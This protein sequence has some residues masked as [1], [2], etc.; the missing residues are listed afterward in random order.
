MICRILVAITDL[1]KK[2][3]IPPF[4]PLAHV[5]EVNLRQ[6]TPE[7]SIRAFRKH[8][9]RLQELGVDVCW[10][11]PVHPIGMKNRKGSLGS[12]YCVRDYNDVNPEFGSLPDF[13]EMV[14]DMHA[15]GMKLVIDWVGNHAAWDNVWV[16]S[17]PEYFL[18]DTNGRFLS[19]Y[20]W[21][22]VIQFNHSHPGQQEAMLDAMAFWVREMGIDGFRADFAHLV[23][24]EFW[25]RARTKLEA[26]KPNLIWLAEAEG[27]DIYQVFDINYGWEWMHFTERF[28]MESMPVSAFRDFIIKEFVEADPS[29]YQLLFTCTHDEN[30]NRGTE[31]ERY[32]IFAQAL[33]VCMYALPLSIPMIYG[34]QEIPNHKR[35]PFFDKDFMV[36]PEQPALTDFYKKLIT[37]RKQSFAGGELFFPEA[38]EGL[39]IFNRTHLDKEEVFAANFGRSTITARITLAGTSGQFRDVFDNSNL[40]VHG[41]L[42]IELPPGGYRLLQKQA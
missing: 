35:L 24:N 40:P 5:Y 23:P 37:F 14:E 32:G 4:L 16:D 15:R 21:H 20:D 42:D 9:P 34:G 31:Y 3:T 19:P 29:R 25:A 10:F 41:F 38:P 22:D 28:V 30:S 18:T 8:L 13:K 39:L 1:L 2:F 11:M 12:Y 7:G 17:H 27:D 36:W 6:Y 26:I 33:A